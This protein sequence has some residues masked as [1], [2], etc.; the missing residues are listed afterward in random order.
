MPS[1][2]CDGIGADYGMGLLPAGAKALL[3]LEDRGLP[4]WNQTWL[5]KVKVWLVGPASLT[6]ADS[7]A[8]SCRSSAPAGVRLLVIMAEQTNKSGIVAIERELEG[9]CAEVSASERG[10]RGGGGGGGGGG[11]L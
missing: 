9:A 3:L 10:G 5:E 4:S 2:T 1:S 6:A 8:G 11:V 7:A